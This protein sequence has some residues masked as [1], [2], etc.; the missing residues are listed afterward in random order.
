MDERSADP[1]VVCGRRGGVGST[2]GGGRADAGRV[3][4]RGVTHE[5]DVPVV[6][7]G[8]RR[9]WESSRENPRGRRGAEGRASP[10][11]SARWCPCSR[12]L[13]R[14]QDHGEIAALVLVSHL[15][16]AQGVAPRRRPRRR[17]RGASEAR[18]RAR[19][20]K[21]R[22]AARA[23]ARRGKA[24]CRALRQ[25][26]RPKCARPA[27][28]A[29]T[30]R[31]ARARDGAA[32]PGWSDISV[33][34][35]RLK[36]RAP[37]LRRLTVRRAAPGARDARD[38]SAIMK[39]DFSV[40]DAPVRA[41]DKLEAEW[42]VPVPPGDPPDRPF[43][44]RAALAGHARARLSARPPRCGRHIC[45]A[46]SHPAAPPRSRRTCTRRTSSSRSSTTCV[47]R[48]P[49]LPPRSGFRY[50][51]PRARASSFERYSLI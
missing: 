32:N 18:E 13:R 12:D 39:L 26:R 3:G 6:Q 42:C 34:A 31:H 9:S 28:P 30:T 43:S 7:A 24:C 41:S 51:A 14:D 49:P 19:R 33:R 21:P 35:R 2:R 5:G 8:A 45:P 29:D 20:A 27:S 17:R 4:G 48:P 40:L 47:P 15:D 36:R 46:R 1:R 11:T 25:H 23:R 37:A 38:G 22:A 50:S 44:T 16:G 10:R